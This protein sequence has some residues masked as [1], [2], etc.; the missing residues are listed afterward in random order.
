MFFTKKKC[1][2]FFEDFSKYLNVVIVLGPGPGT[3]WDPGSWTQGPR[4]SPRLGLYRASRVYIRADR[5]P[6]IRVRCMAMLTKVGILVIKVF[7]DPFM[8]GS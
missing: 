3:H 1:T 7:V 4:L 8:N 6:S 5:A 2:F